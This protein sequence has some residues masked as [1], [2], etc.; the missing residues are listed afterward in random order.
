MN[1]YPKITNC[2]RWHNIHGIN[3]SGH[4]ECVNAIGNCASYTNATCTEKS[5]RPWARQ[6]CRK[7]C[8]LCDGKCQRW[9]SCF[10]IDKDWLVGA[11]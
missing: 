4:I 2:D 6:N 8:N 5:Y 9:Y 10:I 3:I 1:S 11:K 7:H